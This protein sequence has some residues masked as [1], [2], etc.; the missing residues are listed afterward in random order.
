M[1]D[2]RNIKT[3]SQ[4]TMG[5]LHGIHRF[6]LVLTLLLLGSSG[7]G[8]C[9]SPNVKVEI[10]E[11][12]ALESGDCVAF[13]PNAEEIAEDN[14]VAASVGVEA[15]DNL[16]EKLC[17][18]GNCNISLCFAL[19][20]SG[21]ISAEEYELQKQLV[22][23]VAELADPAG[24]AFSAVQ[25]GLSNEFISTSTSNLTLFTE[26][27]DNSKLLK[28]RRT[29]LSAGLAFCIAQVKSN[30]RMGGQKV[31]IIGDG[32]DNFAESSLD[33]VLDAGPTVDIFAVGIGYPLDSKQ[34][35]QVTRG[36][37]DRTF[38]VNNY[39]NLGRTVTNLVQL[40]CNVRLSTS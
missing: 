10:A 26:L 25:Y 35:L 8:Q 15:I 4:A 13:D 9:L 11:S 30:A 18:N 3:F 29:F 36:R 14:N 32:R 16:Q 1:A 21:S 2:N 40:L 33:L 20:G 12:L 22:K 19:D 6:S 31:V 7:L 17:E 37:R 39:A 38:N 23:L 24:A 28:A 34:L 5:Y 27:V